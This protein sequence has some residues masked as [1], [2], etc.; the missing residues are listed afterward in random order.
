M[1]ES[2]TGT[3]LPT[4][5]NIDTDTSKTGTAVAEREATSV[6]FAP[7]ELKWTAEK[8]KDESTK[9][10]DERS[11]EEVLQASLPLEKAKLEERTTEPARK[12]WIWTA[13]LTGV[14]L[15]SFLIGYTVLGGHYW[16]EAFDIHTWI[17]LIKLLF[18]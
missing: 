3:E 18:G 4:N 8:V 12:R 17:H 13:S 2:G 16:R 11:T 14:F 6:T 1:H 9:R 10:V 5:V 7:G 15:V